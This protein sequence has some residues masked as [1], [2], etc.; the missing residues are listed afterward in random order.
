MQLF[1][2]RLVI[3]LLF[4]VVGSS[5]AAREHVNMVKVRTLAG[6]EFSGKLTCN[7]DGIIEITNSRGEVRSFVGDTLD[8]VWKGG[9]LMFHGAALGMLLGVVVVGDADDET[10]ENQQYFKRFEGGMVGCLSL[11]FLGSL[12]RVWET[13]KV[14]ALPTIECEPGQSGGVSLKLGFTL[15]F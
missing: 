7:S 5:V 8:G 3:G 10:K 14:S 15:H 12:I 4:A 9:N 11:G 13:S 6:Q 2:L 1:G